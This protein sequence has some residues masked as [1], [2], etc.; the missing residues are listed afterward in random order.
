MANPINPTAPDTQVPST[1]A[2]LTATAG[3]GQVS[4]GW[5]A[6]TDNVGVTGYEV[7][8]STTAGF[9]PTGA[10]LLTTV[11]GVSYVDTAVTAG[12]TYRYRVI[13]KDAAPNS[14]APSNEASATPTSDTAAPTV[15]VSS[16]AAGATVSGTV[17]LAATAADNVG[18][19][20]VQ[21]K[22]DG[23]NVGAED[24]SSPFAT[25]WN[26]SS[27]TNGTHSVTAV[28]RDAAGN[29]TTS[30]P[31]SITVSNAAP[32]TV[33]PTVSVS[34]PAAGATVSGTVSL[35]ATAADNVGVVGVQFKVDGTNVGAEDTSSPFGASWSSASV[36][37][38][39]HS[40][41]AVARD[42]AGNVTTSAPVSIT[43][44]NAAPTGLV[45]AFGF[46]EVSGTSALDRSGL[47]NN[48]TVSGAT[49]SAS[50]RHGGALSFDGVNDSV[51]VPDAASLDLT[52]NMT[53]SAWVRPTGATGWRTVLMKERPGGQSYSLYASS[54]VAA[55]SG[56]MVVG[57]A[58]QELLSPS[59]LP[60]NVWS[61]LAFTYDGAFTR[62][63]INGVEVINQ[64]LTGSAVVGTGA[65][66]I[67][68]N[69]IWGEWFAGLIDEVRLYNRALTP[70]QLQTDMANPINPTA[71]DTQV[72][73]TPAGLTATAGIG[74]VS[75]GWTASTDNVG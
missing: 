34:S 67:G 49:R 16:P 62:L 29:V 1:P 59:P 30:A 23:T 5:T 72:P 44:S 2:G 33:A 52:N 64:P 47:G 74:Q 35:A 17:S 57:S 32:D 39:T 3:I 4:L 31:V 41:T 40:V 42:A 10:T 43:V 73:S 11:S 15:S 63:Y 65:L 28:A 26:S 25:S 56:W 46:D 37:N 69:A 61:H 27:V 70:T 22:V 24:T 50:G 7:H 71:P 48:G 13:A 20:G 75:L 54:G 21:F 9:T 53:L 6:S 45:G 36:A 60:A 55:P 66:K 38:G 18:V 14:S 51:S 68:G 12:T 8:R 19:V 58:E